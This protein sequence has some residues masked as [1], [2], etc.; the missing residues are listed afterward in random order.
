MLDFE[1]LLSAIRNR[2]RPTVE[3]DIQLYPADPSCGSCNLQWK[4]RRQAERSSQAHT[5]LMPDLL[6]LLTAEAI[7]PGKET[8]IY[9]N[10]L[11][12]DR[13]L[14]LLPWYAL[15]GHQNACLLYSCHGP[16][17]RLKKK[18]IWLG[19]AISKKKQTGNTQEIYARHEHLKVQRDAAINKLALGSVTIFFSEEHE[20]GS[21]LVSYCSLQSRYISRFK[22]Y[23]FSVYIFFLDK[24][25]KLTSNS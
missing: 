13:W 4:Q 11:T 12:S 16:I 3:A 5:Q 15:A 22:L 25:T 23:K 18:I 24:G 7:Y 10:K 20:K 17:R 19:S 9:W 8:N 2:V 1:E 6:Q 14:L 21:G